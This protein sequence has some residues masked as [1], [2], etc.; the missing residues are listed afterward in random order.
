M[1]YDPS[2]D[3]A[4][5]VRPA[6]AS[7]VPYLQLPH[8]DGDTYASGQTRHP[9]I[10]YGTGSPEGAIT[11]NVGDAY[12]QMDGSSNQV[13]WLKASGNGTDTGWRGGAPRGTG[14]FWIDGWYMDN[15]PANQSSVAMN[16]LGDPTLAPKEFHVPAACAVV[17]LSLYYPSSHNVGSITVKVKKDVPLPSSVETGLEVTIPINTAGTYG[18]TADAAPYPAANGCLTGMLIAPYIE[19]SADLSPTT[20]DLRV[21]IGLVLL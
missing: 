13:L 3:I 6:G 15:I 2:A 20:L 21:S 17:G 7:P 14:E 10:F 1:T 16:R 12:L 18:D 8:G 19:S 5:P 9:R 4:F 11:G